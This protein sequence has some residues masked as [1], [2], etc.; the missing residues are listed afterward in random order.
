MFLWLSKLIRQ[1]RCRHRWRTDRRLADR[2]W[3]DLCRA[4]RRKAA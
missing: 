1:V 2:E 4:K 3:C